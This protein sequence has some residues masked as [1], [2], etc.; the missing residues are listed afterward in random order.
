[1]SIDMQVVRARDFIRLAAGGH[2]DLESS[3]Q[4][5]GNVAKAMVSHGLDRAILDVRDV[6]NMLTIPE[7]YALA[8][9]FREAGFWRDHQLAVVHRATRIDRADFFAACATSRGWNVAAFDAYEDA[10]NWLTT[11]EPVLPAD[12]GDCGCEDTSDPPSDDTS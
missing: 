10:I 3:R 12:C 5:L 2:V 11:A 8:T 4:A 6:E 9:T 1:M 7:L